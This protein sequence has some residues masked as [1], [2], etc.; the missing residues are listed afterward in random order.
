MAE[1]TNRLINQS[2][3]YLLQ[4]AH[5][6]VN[7][8]PWGEEALTL[9]QQE[10][11]PI[12]VS[13]GYSACHWCHVMERESFEDH[14]VAELMNQYFINIKVDR[15]ERP[16]IDHL[17]MD[18]VQA[19]GLQGG[20]PLN[21]VLTPD[22]KPFYGG[23]YFPKNA[24]IDLLDKIR[25]AYKHKKEQIAQTADKLLE[26]LRQSATETYAL[27]ADGNRIEK[28]A[29][30]RAF[31]K[32][33]N[34]FDTEMGG[35]KG[36]P[37]FPMP[38]IWQFVLRYHHLSGSELAYD[39]VKTTLEEMAFGGI[40]DQLGGGFA[41]YSVDDEWFAP[42]FEKMLYDNGQLV[43]LY[44]E[45]YQLSKNSWFEKVVEESIAFIQRELSSQEGGF[46]AALDAD[47]EGEEG[48][49]YTWTKAEV[50]TLFGHDA[51]II[52][53]YFNI[54][55][56]GNWEEGRNIL[57]IDKDPD[58]VA[59]L[60]NRSIPETEHLLKE[61]KERLLKVRNERVS[62]GLDDK[63]LAGWNGLMLRGIA[64]AYQVFGNESYLAMAKK[65]ADFIRQR[66]FRNGRLYRTFKH[67]KAQIPAYLEDYAAVI[68]AMLELY[69]ANFNKVHLLFADQLTQ[70][71]M[72]QFF[73]EGEQFFYYTAH[74]SEQLIARKKELF[75]NVIPSSNAI[76]AENLYVLGSLTA[77]KQY[78]DLATT[79]VEKAMH[80]I[81]MNPRYMS[82]WA[83]L[84]VMITKPTAEVAIVGPTYKE[85]ALALYQ[86]YLPCKVA[87]AA[88]TADSEISL[89]HQRA[90]I[91]G[92]DTY[93][94]CYNHVCQKPVTD[95]EEAIDLIRKLG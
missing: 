1:H 56:E 71:V 27:Y 26:S 37:K 89:L 31:E 30:D 49:F 5:N 23:T 67:D 43:G 57:T 2:S 77:N 32:L 83:S 41:R 11:K 39:Q 3:P 73:D 10:D 93:Y 17:Y 20:W 15:E 66:L 4:H 47:T 60:V 9:A 54:T 46:Y 7:W 8:Y 16:D 52:C 18:A 55:E 84:A 81:E 35:T 65:N 79:M 44:A 24:W 42:H 72:M 48:K 36:A 74:D 51:S 14:E 53:E 22:Q 78:T 80:L 29:L 62:P 45:A 95:L 50:D 76:M 34:D 82:H 59:R 61:L 86:H 25:T 87:A 92:K 90:A 21:V 19:M 85:S 69:Q 94:V 38:S 68:A 6:P 63:I 13:I 28:A 64:K 33:M 40:Y 88:A 91:E 12:I 75:D 70:I 58:M